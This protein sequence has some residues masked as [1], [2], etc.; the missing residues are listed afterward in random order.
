MAMTP[1][2]RAK[3]YSY[4]RRSNQPR[5]GVRLEEDQGEEY[6]MAKEVA[7][8]PATTPK[9]KSIQKR[10]SATARLFE[11]NHPKV[12]EKYGSGIK[13]VSTRN[14]SGIQGSTVNKVYNTYNT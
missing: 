4:T 13:Q 7:G 3:A 8:Q 14:K 11:K 12:A 2:Q 6:K 9:E 5:V 10:A 1:E